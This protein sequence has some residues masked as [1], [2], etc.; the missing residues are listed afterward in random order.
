MAQ[1]TSN[2][3]FWRDIRVLRVLFP[4]PLSRRSHLISRITL[5]QHA[6]GTKES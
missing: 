2:I 5:H 1:D 6:E 3:P 4:N